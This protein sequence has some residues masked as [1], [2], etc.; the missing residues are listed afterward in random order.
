MA[1]G[2][3]VNGQWTTAWTEHNEKGQFQ[4]M[5]TLFRNWVT[6]DGSSGFKAEAGR[7]HLY[8]SL[9]CPWA[10]RTALLWKL[11][12]LEPVVGLSIVD[13]IISEQGWA[14]SDN[15][16]CVRDDV[17]NADFLWQIYV[18]ANPT[19]TGRVTVPVLWDK[20][21]N[22]IVNNESRQIITMFN[23][24]FNEDATHASV[25]YYPKHLQQ[26]ID[27]TIDA[28]YQPIN[29][30]VY[31]SG[32]A[33]SQAAY[34]EAVT[35]LFQALDHWETVLSQQRYLCGDQVT[36]ADW[37]IFTTLFRFDLAYHGLFKCNLRRLVDYPNLWNYFRDLY[38]QPGVKEMCDATHVKQLY[39]AGVAELNPNRIIP[40]GPAIAFDA[41]HDR[42][43]HFPASPATT[44]PILV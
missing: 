15:P 27:Q 22:T 9:G 36:L 25:D 30:G 32:F 38:Q 13:P 28:I 21:T 1:L 11:K 17:N 31:R 42:N 14:F 4:R 40:M 34:E 7:Y 43:L 18:K 5:P 24:E 8:I 37:C 44:H 3:L 16:G 26:Q 35:E 10:H 41:P 19:Y 12:G 39:Y 2:Q 6:A 29:N 23:A 33:K 20:H